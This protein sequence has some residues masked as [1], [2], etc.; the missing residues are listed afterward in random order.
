MYKDTNT[1]LVIGNEKYNFLVKTV[2]EHGYLTIVRNDLA[3]I[4]SVLKDTK[5]MVVII[6]CNNCTG[7]VLEFVFNVRDLYPNIPVIIF[8]DIDNKLK[9]NNKLKRQNIS[10]I[11]NNYFKLEEQIERIN[12]DNLV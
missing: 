12:M 9:D 7:D 11:K 5:P 3:K 2:F 6:D 1:A 4:I 8:G 10:F